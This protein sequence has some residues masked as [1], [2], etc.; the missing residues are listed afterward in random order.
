[1]PRDNR[2]APRVETIS[3]TD[4]RHAKTP[5]WMMA[6][7][8]TVLLLLTTA[9]SAT[10]QQGQN[11]RFRHLLVEDGLSQEAVQ[12]I[13][14]DHRGLLWFGTQDGLNRYD[15]YD[16]TVFN[17]DPK[18]PASL[19]NG[20]IWCLFED[21]QGT[22][23]IGTDGGG[24]NRFLPGRQAFERFVS[25]PSD[26]FSLSHDSVRVIYEDRSGR[27]WIGTDGGG[28]NRLDPDTGTFTRFAHDPSSPASLSND[29]VRT[30]AE[31]SSGALWVGTDGGGINI[32]DA[33]NGNFL[34]VRHD[35]AVPHGL[36]D[37]RVRAIRE[38]ADGDVWIGTYESGLDLYDP[39]ADRFTHF[40]HAPDD[41]RSL[42]DDR[43]RDLF[44]DSTG[45][46]WVATD[47]G[48]S[49]WVAETRSFVS[50]RHDP[51]EPTSLSDDRVNTVTED[52]GGVLWVGT[53]NG[54]NKWNL[55]MGAFEIYQRNPDVSNGLASDV[56]T[57]F[58][59]DADGNIW[60]GT[61]GGGLTRVDALTGAM[62]SFAHDPDD[63]TSLTENRVMELYADE[64]GQLWIGTRSGGLDRF[65]PTAG[66]FT[67][68]RHDPE[69]PTS[70]SS[71]G[72]TVITGDRFGA[73]W[74]GTYRGGL[75]RFDPK[76]GGFARYRHD[77]TNP[78]SLGDD[79]V[80]ALH[81]DETGALWIGT[82]GA[83]LSRYDRRSGTFSHYRHDPD[84][85]T[86]LSS[87]AAWAI[88][89]DRQGGFWIGTRGGGLNY[90]DPVNWRV[91]NP[92]FRRYLRADGLPSSVVY[93]IL[94]DGE[95]NLWLST[96]RGLTRLNPSTGQVK[97][98]DVTHGL[99]GNDFTFGAQFRSRDGRMFFGGSNG[100]NVFQPEQ[101]RDNEHAP[102]VILTEFLKFNRPVDL[103][104]HPAGDPLHLSHKDSVVGFEFAA[105]D[106]T[107]PERN[108][109]RY[110]LEGFEDDWT[111]VGDLRRI[112]Y[113]NLAS[114]E[115]TLRVQAS[116]NDGLWNEEGLA[117]ALVVATPPWQTWWAILLY[118]LCV[119]GAVL[120]IVRR[121]MK[122]LEQ[123]AEYSHQLEQEVAKRTDK[124]K[125]QNSQ[126]VKL[127]HRLREVSVTD[128]LTGLWNRR[129][130]ANEI[131][132][133]LA[134]IR[135]SQTLNQQKGLDQPDSLDCNLLFLMMDLDGLK[136]V[137]DA[138]GHQAGDRA[139]VQMKEILVRVC[140]QSDT[141]IRW[142]G[143]EFL[144]LGRQ[145]ARD[146]AAHLAARIK[147]AVEDH[148]FDLS[149]GDF[150]RLSCSIG[151]TFFPFL[152]SAPRLFSWE[153]VLDM[154]D[155]ALYRAKQTGR[156]RWVGVL[157]VPQVDPAVLMQHKDD[158]LDQLA[159][160]GIVELPSSGATPSSPDET[161]QRAL[162]P[163][164]PRL[165][166]RAGG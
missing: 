165:V 127:N 72:V 99:Q 31:D 134:L 7:L 149:N 164:R 96:S 152:P 115:Y 45:R 102:P 109:Y 123:Q 11:V 87:N 112:T 58:S 36:S 140:R 157:S 21:S 14:Q 151:F 101:V 124:L 43:V 80:L 41:H 52:H 108:Q 49:T 71:N 105:L 130:L 50:Y 116:N 55:A 159:R 57:A 89:Q 62:T 160:A 162:D 158:E 66:R 74:V 120:A 84:D 4:T 78:T 3:M 136:G 33:A 30:I 39:A 10:A 9:Q 65:D 148:Q 20:W 54:L 12:A 6:R 131:E 24:L 59:E 83:G 144:V 98:Y 38:T 119:V 90:W 2:H 155:R 40:V 85:G 145:T 63:P 44:E 76:T 70:L 47:G 143:D 106:F 60:V 8:A 13:L 81:A 32:F 142:G 128:S 79:R 27:L 88:H 56:I 86:S 29:R 64:V 156:N 161:D 75:N 100:F 117:L 121:Q 25:D 37:D 107:A 28:L 18:D 129:Y 166:E 51:S 94:E 35:S 15:G 163:P 138:Y 126:L 92:V 122:K 19:S 5:R 68:Y 1:M 132:K 93:G 22:L 16:V 113:T 133:D 141:L 104:T 46:L 111:E 61:Y 125:L 53:Y 67:H 23:W 103:G 26:P 34:H 95:D 150:V 135:R 91:L 48:L 154:A 114:G 17:H 146:A 42:A 137:N 77:P 97:N 110:R 73:L 118:V 139:I 82:D 69:D 147:Q 153:Q